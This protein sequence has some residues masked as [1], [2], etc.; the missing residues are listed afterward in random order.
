[1]NAHELVQ[2]LRALANRW[3][4]LAR[5]YA[6][7]GRDSKD[8]K[9]SA[10]YRGYAEGYYKAA[11][12]LAAQLKGNI[13][14]APIVSVPQSAVD[15]EQIAVENVQAVSKHAAPSPI[16]SFEAISVGE[17]INIL[18]FAGV[19]PRDVSIMDGNVVYAV[20]SRWQPFT[21]HE[22]VAKIAGA[23][24]RIVILGFGKVKDSSDPYVEFAFKQG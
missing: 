10:Y 3:A 6:R 2:A 22:R 4:L 18:E 23:D 5:D 11:T 9:Q 13:V 14:D 15:V 16:S 1:M 8:E 12:E 20:F 17:I 19:S 24:L 21:E 7:E